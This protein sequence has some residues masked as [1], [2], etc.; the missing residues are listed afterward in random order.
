MSATVPRLPR[1]RRVLFALIV[2]T[3]L[4]VVCEGTA[5]LTWWWPTGEW[6]SLAQA[7][8]QRHRV[9]DPGHEARAR[10]TTFHT[11]VHPYLGFSYCPDWRGKL[12]AEAP[13]TDWGFTD[14]MRRSPVRKRGPNKVAVGLL[15]ASLA[16]IFSREGAEALANDKP[17]P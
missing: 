11:D 13:I 4:V 17:G 9:P 16:R 10:E 1:S 15:G 7:R 2:L 6:F 3:G 14:P 5:S 8:H 12:Q